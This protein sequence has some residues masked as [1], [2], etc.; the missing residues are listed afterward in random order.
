MS[1]STRKAGCGV[2]QT[3]LYHATDCFPYLPI[4]YLK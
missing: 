4:I 3:N 2:M 1:L